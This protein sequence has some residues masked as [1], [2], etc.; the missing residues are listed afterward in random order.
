MSRIT[1]IPARIALLGCGNVGSA[2]ARRLVEDGPRLG[3]EL[4]SVLVRDR[5]RGRGLPAGLFT[6]RFNDVLNADPDL[7]IELLGGVE[8][9]AGF[10]ETLLRR[11]IPVV[12]ANKTLVAHRGTTLEQMAME[13][14]V[15]LA[16]EG[17][18]CAG[19]P[20]LAALR[21][22]AGDRVTAVRGIVNGTCN[23]ILSR[24][25]EAALDMPDALAEASRRGLVEPDPTADL[26]GQDSAEKL[27]VL[28]RAARIA[29]LTPGLIPRTGIEGVTPADIRAAA[30]AGRVIRLLAEIEADGTARV[31]PALLPRSHP[32]A[33]VR[34]EDNGVFIEARDAGSLFLRGPGAGPGPTT[35]AVLGD[36]LRVLVRIPASLDPVT[37]R[38]DMLR[39]HQIRA[40]PRYALSPARVLETLR[41]AGIGAEEVEL[42]RHEARLLTAPSAAS[43]A[44]RCARGL[45]EKSLVLPIVE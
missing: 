6:D 23:Y 37:C 36:V 27:C 17:S 10:V 28:A 8:P 16:C 2:V 32:L 22:L 29:D 30:R 38:K 7:A 34:R 44:A 14:D 33:G 35:S 4:V 39:R 21:Q 43:E 12:T 3:L 20:V 25:E 41:N 42:T 5:R 24:M 45:A 13:G 15:E 31:G 9:A 11:G 1:R 18:V 26:S 19:V 40:Q